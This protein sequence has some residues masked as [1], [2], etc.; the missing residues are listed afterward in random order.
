LKRTA[1]L[2]VVLLTAAACARAG[3]SGSAARQT[4]TLEVV[5]VVEVD[6]SR[7]KEALPA[8][9]ADGSTAGEELQEEASP[10]LS[11]EGFGGKVT[12]T[13]EPGAAVEVIVE[14]SLGSTEYPRAAVRLTI[15]DP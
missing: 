13:S 6:P 3:G 11:P 9:Q 1:V 4:L 12:V 15:T 2:L 14:T 10:A 7:V 5:P 8:E